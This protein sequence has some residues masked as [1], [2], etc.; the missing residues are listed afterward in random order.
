MH[1]EHLQ[2]VHTARV[3]AGWLVAI[4]VTS[5]IILALIGLGQ[6]GRAHV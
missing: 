3:L 4:A 2:N 6:I 5:L 1:T